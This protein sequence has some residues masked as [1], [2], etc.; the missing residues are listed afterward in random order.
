MYH[1]NY[2]LPKYIW[3]YDVADEKMN[4]EGV[5]TKIFDGCSAEARIWKIEDILCDNGLKRA[6]DLR[7]FDWKSLEDLGLTSAE[8]NRI[9]DFVKES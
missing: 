1:D 7:H 9:M 2:R 3:N 8:A 5:I 6:D 4:I